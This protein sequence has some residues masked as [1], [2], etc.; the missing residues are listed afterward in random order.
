MDPIKLFIRRP[1]FTLMLVVSLVVFG[2]FS[3]PKIGID[4]YPNV[5]VPIV[6]VTTLSPGADPE[7][8][9]RD[10]SEPLEEALNTLPGLDKL[11]SINLENISQV[12]VAF[13]MDADIDIAAQDVR[14]R[15]QATV[16]Q[17]PQNIEAPRVEKLDLGS[18]P[19]VTLALSGPLQDR[20]LSR[21]AEDQVKPALQQI[22]GVGAV[23]LTGNR[24][25]EI[26]IV[27]D[28]LRLRGA[29]LTAPEVAQMLKA[30]HLDVPGGRTAEGRVERTVKLRAEAENIDQLRDLVLA[31]PDAVP[32]R[33]R[34]VADVVD[35]TEEARSL[36]LL[37]GQPAIGFVVRKQSGGNTVQVAEKVNAALGKLAATLPEGCR[38]QMVQDNSRF[39]RASISG[40]ETDMVLGG[41]FAILVVLFFLRNGRSTLVS[42][43]ALPTSV[44][45]TFAFMSALDFT[46]N[47][48][49]MLALTLSIGLLIDD[50]IV[51]IEN[52]VR[53]LEAGMPAHEAAAEG[54][55]QIA[56]AVLAVTLTIVAVFVPVAF[57]EGMIGRFFY[58]F[59][60]T[61]AIAVVISYAV[62]MTLTPALSARVLKEAKDA[63]T[64]GLLS[65]LVERILLGTESGYRAILRWSL[66]HRL[67]IVGLTV[68]LFAGT[69]A[70]AARMNFSFMPEQDMSLVQVQ[71]E[72]PAGTRLKDTRVQLDDLARQV[73]AL[74][75]VERTFSSAGQGAQQEVHKGQV[76]VNLAPIAHR[77][78][79]QTEFKQYL[80]ENLRALPGVTLAVSDVPI[81]SMGSSNAQLVQFGIRGSNWEDLQAAADKTLAA[82]KSNPMF[83]DV[84]SSYRPGKPQ[85]D[86][87]V[88]ADRASALGIPAGQ[89]GQALR[90][91]LGK[92][93]I[94]K[95]RSEGDSSDI[96]ATLPAEVLSDPAKLGS[97]Q[98]RAPG[99]NL[100]ELRSFAEIKP[101]Q[102]A[103]LIERSSQMRQIMLYADLKGTSLSEAIS[104]L[105]DYAEKEYPPGIVTGFE[106]QGGEMG[107]TLSAFAMAM[108]LGIVLVFIVL[109]AQFESLLLPLS[110]MMALP[111]SIIGAIG[112]LLASHQDMSIFAMI[113]MIMLMG[114]V[115]KNGIL[116]VEF[117][118][119]VKQEAGSA[120]EAMMQAGP[121]R[122]RPILMTTIAMIAGMIPV[123]LAR[124]DGAETRVP[125][126][127][128]VIG[129]LITSTLLTLVVVPV[130]YTLLEQVSRWAS[131]LTHCSA[132]LPTPKAAPTT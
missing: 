73:R 46:F 33:L 84:D 13:D 95:L 88:N 69:I 62:S 94:G 110:I 99:G 47:I 48:V 116:I 113:G 104:W 132:K 35:G 21:I 111:L 97:V 27:L 58:Q 44:V 112:G 115:T 5:D 118:N 64:A 28:P 2:L 92:D 59:G 17:L 128:A 79:N 86:V 41:L 22:A 125:M 129:G 89:L 83:V 54:T 24:L 66:S 42:A 34:D 60:T 57:M 14:D 119:H 120:F 8:V 12:I 3:Y 15:V 72:M 52:I 74:E 4:Q 78:Y 65:K 16:S 11:R 117:A 80:R 75:G 77:A 32:V 25:R 40:V 36:S 109:A 43:I 18:A 127:L 103:A 51:V 38:L 91:A 108:G 87:V 76:L 68:L 105:N 90:A 37:D 56:V 100:V 82:M 50:A 67:S 61:V 20:E 9:E 53:K 114:L 1:I 71:L 45:G 107:K 6:T 126:A 130:F 93:V 29:G 23:E 98:V 85:L 106:G 19:V 101:G 30:Q 81:M 26:Q 121:I 10:I 55:G 39:I 131:R 7:S 31:S 123:A 63:Q 96:V 122:L 70:L 49:T 124:G 102:G